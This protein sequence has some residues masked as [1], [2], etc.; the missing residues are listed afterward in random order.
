[1]SN[2]SLKRNVSNL[3]FRLFSLVF[4]FFFNFFDQKGDQIIKCLLSRF[5]SNVWENARA[6]GESVTPETEQELLEGL[7]FTN[8]KNQEDTF[9]HE[10]FF[11]RPTEERKNRER[12]TKGG[13]A[14]QLF[15]AMEGKKSAAAYSAII[16]GLCKFGSGEK[17]KEFYEMMRKE[18]FQP[19]CQA[20][21]GLVR[22]YA[23]AFQDSDERWLVCE[24]LMNDM[25]KAEVAP[26]VRFFNAVLELLSRYRKGG[27]PKRLLQVYAEMQRLGISPS[28][29][30]F[31]PLISVY[32][33]DGGKIYGV[34]DQV[35]KMIEDKKF[36]VRDDMDASFFVNAMTVITERIKDVDMGYCKISKISM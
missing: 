12:W 20:Y 6:S 11:Y 33:I 34:M 17:A 35:L 32:A 22:E 2:F 36:D 21:T 25:A 23:A 13:P 5:Y 7:C 3:C 30:T 27:N 29:G 31:Y 15:E 28:L 19:S 16:C 26:D 1:M 10:E 18:N 24:T 4:S 14:D 8:S 9:W